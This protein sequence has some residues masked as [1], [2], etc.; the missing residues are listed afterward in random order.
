M[1]LAVYNWFAIPIQVS[2]DPPGMENTFIIV[3]N[4][5]IDL[6]FAV[7]IFV[8]FRTTYI[9]SD[10]GEEVFSSKKIAINYLRGR[11][12]FDLFATIPFDTIIEL[13]FSQTSKEFQSFGVLKLIR[14]A[15][16][17]K[18]VTYLNVK[19]D[20]KIGLKLVKL[21][22]FLSIY[23]H[24]LGCIW[25]YMINQQKQW[26]PPLDTIYPVT[27]FYHEGL[28]Y[29][30]W[31]S[32]YHAILIETSN[33]IAPRIETIQVVFCTLMILIGA[34]VNAYIFGLIIFLVAAMNDKSNKFIQKLDIWNIAMKNLKIPQ[35]IQN[36][37][38]GYLIYTD[39]LLDSQNELETFLSWLSPSLKQ[40]VTSHLFI[41]TLY[42][43]IVFKGRKQLIDSISKSLLIRTWKPE[44]TIIT[45]GDNPDNIYFIAKGGCNVYVRNKVGLRIRAN[46]LKSGDYFGEV[47]I[48]NESKRTATV[49]SN[50]YST[51]A[52]LSK[53]DFEA[54][55]DKHPGAFRIIKD[56]RKSYSDEW[57]NFL[58]LNL[59]S[60]EYLK[61][62]SEHIF[63]EL[64]WDLKEETF[65][66]DSFIWKAGDS[67]NKI[68]FIVSG[69]IEVTV[70]HF[71]KHIPIET[72]YQGCSMGEYG[73]LGD[74]T[75]MFTAKA[76]SS[77]VKVVTISKDVVQATI[78]MNP[79]LRILAENESKPL[80]V[81]TDLFLDFR[82]IRTEYRKSRNK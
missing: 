70:N 81:H 40:K 66:K 80:R 26:I 11:F 33:D 23:F 59:T 5:I 4:S 72:L 69:Q 47:A 31:M 57:K 73:I 22:F 25:F 10:T 74:Y 51:L 45:Q 64:Y 6:L 2:F 82:M 68:Y 28:W 9:D 32:V 78:Y 21:L 41:S 17:N 18:I 42:N 65:E 56:K 53:F 16:L 75:Y 71:N 48:L 63:Q 50:N 44:D 46:V 49:R 52:Y 77:F 27:N 37:V 12:W 29:Q 14:I 3:L 54:I 76:K 13:I 8:I 55:F 7:D 38:V 30:Y 19:E 43:T 58:I 36:D 67:I 15:R 34:V 60:I 61:S 39:G 35:E 20:V 24:I 79:D 1:V 62:A